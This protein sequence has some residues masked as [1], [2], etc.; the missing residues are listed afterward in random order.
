MSS[1]KYLKH[2]PTKLYDIVR[3]T[4]NGTILSTSTPDSILYK[5]GPENIS[6]R[7]KYFAFVLIYTGTNK[8]KGNI[9]FPK[10]V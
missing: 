7:T 1:T 6:N 5:K 8:E 4:R 3:I 2:Q 9:T 10:I